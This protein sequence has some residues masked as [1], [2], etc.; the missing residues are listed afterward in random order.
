MRLVWTTI[1]E[2]NK[3]NELKKS[4]DSGKVK[5]CMESLERKTLSV[6]MANIKMDQLLRQ[7]L[8]ADDAGRE[9]IARKIAKEYIRVNPDFREEMEIAD[10]IINVTG[11]VKVYPTEFDDEPSFSMVANA[12]DVRT[13][14][15]ESRN[16]ILKKSLEALFSISN[17]KGQ[18]LFIRTEQWIGVYRDCIELGFSIENDYRGFVDQV[19]RLDIADIPYSCTVEVLEKYDVGIFQK[20]QE[21]W[22]FELYK[23]LNKGRYE[24]TFRDLHSV[25]QRFYK[26]LSENI[27]QK[28]V[29]SINADNNGHKGKTKEKF[30]FVI[31][32][33][34]TNTVISKILSYLEGK[35]P[36]QAKDVM[37]PIRAAQ[38]AGV[39]RR[40]T[41]EEMLLTFPDYCPNSKASVSKYTK[42]DDTPYSDEAFK[43]MVKD[44]IS[45]LNGQTNNEK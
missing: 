30:S 2:Q 34:L 23:T 33:T 13:L 7:F 5:A 17:F 6:F 27:P 1:N 44:F 3:Y 42:E 28:R 24:K 19:R 14:S 26:I 8:F 31:I 22:T 15:E 4:A 41:F 40:I 43:A 39:I 35:S 10:P 37:K 38:D 18:K 45:L 16:E 29:V 11:G 9:D 12:V 25:A 32:S 20:P 36:S 21:E